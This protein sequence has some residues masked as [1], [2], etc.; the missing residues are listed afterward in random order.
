[1]RIVS[2]PTCNSA[3]SLLRAP[4][5]Q[6]LPKWS[7]AQTALPVIKADCQQKGLLHECPTTQCNPFLLPKS[8]RAASG[9]DGWGLRCAEN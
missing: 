4:F 7:D 9:N 2:V 8:I 3:C 1:M 6:I 5:T